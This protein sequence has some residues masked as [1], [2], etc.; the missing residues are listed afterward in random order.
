MIKSIEKTPPLAG[1]LN[2]Y[3]A[4]MNKFM[5]HRKDKYDKLVKSLP[6]VMP[7]LIRHP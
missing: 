6:I 7:D 1:A 5:W 2:P 3:P 4:G